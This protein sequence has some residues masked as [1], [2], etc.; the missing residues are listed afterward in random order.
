[1]ITRIAIKQLRTQWRKTEWRALLIALFLMITLMTLLNLTADRLNQSLT[2]KSA[3][4]LGADLIINSSRP[5][6][7]EWMTWL[8]Q[9]AVT[10]T[11][12]TQFA[13]MV[14]ANGG[15]LLTSIRAV[16][17]PYPL[18][19][20][21]IT[22]PASESQVPA[23]QSVWVEQAVLDRL[24]LARG[25]TLHIG[26]AAFTISHQLVASPDRG[27]GFRSFNPQIIMN[28]ADLEATGVLTLGSRAQY[29]I[30][31]SGESPI[32]TPLAENI[33]A[34][35]QSWENLTSVK[36]DQP[37]G[38]NVLS[39]ASRYLK[40]SAVF[41]LLMGA[42]AVFLSLKRYAA[43]QH[44]RAALLL[45]FG[46][47]QRKL[48]GLYGIQL[49]SAWLMITPISLLA[50]F[51]LHQLLLFWLAELLPQV[52][53]NFDATSLFISAVTALLILCIAGYSTLLPLTKTPIVALMRQEPISSPTI[54][55][56][57]YA[58][59]ALLL[60][61]LLASFVDSWLLALSLSISLL[62]GGWLA[63]MIVQRLIQLIN[64]RL[65]SIKLFSLLTL[66]IRQQRIWHRLQGGVLT[67]LL[68]L[69]AIL[70]F[71]REDLMSAWQ[72]QLPKDTPNNFV[73]NIQPWE[74][75]RVTDWLTENG[76]NAKL[77]PMIRGRITSLN[78]RSI[79]EA[80]TPEQ[81][82]HNTLNRELNLT[83]SAELPTHNPLVEGAWSNA[84]DAISIEQSMAQALSIKLGDQL[85]FSVGS[86]TFTAT[87]R[88]I[89]QVE[90]QSFQPNFYVIFSPSVI[91]KLP[92]TYIT[93]FKL[94]A[95]QRS[96]S[97]ELLKAFPTLTLIDVDQLLKQ[98]QSLIN[99]LSDSASLIYLLTL[100]CG[101][102]LVIMTLQ[103]S[104]HQRRFETALLRTLG[105]SEHQTSRLDTLEYLLI[106]FSCGITA[107]ALS[108][109][110]MFVV[111]QKLL[112]IEPTFHLSLWLALPVLATLFFAGCGKL[113][114]TPM[115]LPKSYRFLKSP[116]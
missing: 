63:G 70:F 26:Y 30:L 45:S 115:S 34:K 55:R 40:L 12:V 9:Q 64:G 69:M 18:R 108:E 87:V 20:E 67:L 44:K 56:T 43:D 72:S 105:A 50:G 83:W 89:R 60:L 113:I 104:L 68:T 94:E 106:G 37:A 88:S 23:P 73:I 62:L 93:S 59:T 6:E 52:L 80:F 25:D 35:L 90:W 75:D 17:S 61:V 109:L 82:Q 13:S 98:A 11:Q 10:T 107:S 8:D 28:S 32:I 65:H 86:Q 97:A 53:P 41:A 114:R 21:I 54:S 27:S 91:D 2:L 39:N 101:L 110:I 49:L 66:R 116:G 95:Y 38:R 14:E 42:F 111:Y 71:I 103:Q 24:N 58:V 48:A 51:G 81:R 47:T 112:Q 29:R 92:A 102:T 7:P 33:E 74:K 1:M 22:A 85:S 3:E 19:G 96:V 84:K 99:S 78:N 57:T 15:M 46:L 4:L 36:N 79:E 5:L 76:V 16:T 100:L 77:Y 31:I